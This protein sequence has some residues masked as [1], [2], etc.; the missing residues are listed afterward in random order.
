MQHNTQNTNQLNSQ[1]SQTNSLWNSLS[2]SSQTMLTGGMTVRLK[3]ARL[4]S[5]HSFRGLPDIVVHDDDD[6]S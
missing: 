6:D 2:E 5:Q 4:T 1:P 3:R